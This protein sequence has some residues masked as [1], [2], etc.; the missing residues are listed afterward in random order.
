MMQT[1]RDLITLVA[2]TLQHGHV[3]TLTVVSGSMRPALRV[4]DRVRVEPATPATVR[5]GDVVV[6]DTGD[7]LLTHRFLGWR[8]GR[9]LTK[10]D[11]LMAADTFP[12]PP[13]LIGRVVGYERNGVYRDWRTPRARWGHWALGQVGYF[14]LQCARL[15][16][17]APLHWLVQ[18]GWRAL[19]MV[20][21][22]VARL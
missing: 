8:Q 16:R 20:C 6:L 7:D 18:K 2:E 22:Y 5:F 13:R 11:A 19:G 1:S 4:G 12:R 10:G 17:P 9:M 21:V 14:A 15:Q 3:V